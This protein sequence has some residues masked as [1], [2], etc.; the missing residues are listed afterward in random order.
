[1]I[2]GQSIIEIFKGSFVMDILLVC[3]IV[4]LALI[5]ERFIYFTRNRFDSRKGYLTFRQII[6][7]QGPSAA[8]NHANQKKNSLSGLFMVALNNRHLESNN[9]LDILASFVIEE[10]VKFDRYLGGMGTLANAATLLG[11]LGTVMG[12]IKAFH[13]ISITGSGGPA[14]ISSGIAEALLTTAFGLFIGIPTLFF[15][16]YFSKKSNELSMELDGI[17]DRIVV[18]FN[19]LKKQS[20][21]TKASDPASVPAAE[22]AFSPQDSP[23]P[24]DTTWKF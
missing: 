18:L 10:K 7:G 9:L 15:Y 13:N 20:S 12:L 24:A 4:A 8:L 2:L 11:L 5:I 17:S 21:G 22:S 19:N 3:S 16:N 1:M 23:P 14:V 6:R